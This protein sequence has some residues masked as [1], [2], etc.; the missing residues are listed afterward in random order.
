MRV[1]LLLTILAVAFAGCASKNDD[2]ATPPVNNSTATDMAPMVMTATIELGENA[3]APG[4]PSVGPGSMYLKSTGMDQL[5]V[6]MAVNVTVKNAG[7]MAHNVVIDE[8]GFKTGDIA[9]GQT[10]SFTLTPTKDGT[11]AMYC[12]KG[13]PDPTGQLPTSHRAAGMEGKAT[14]KKAA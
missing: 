13:A 14:V 3:A 8:L 4:A 5:V 12:D 10:K 11:F 1:L 7:G 6:G 9:A 2:T